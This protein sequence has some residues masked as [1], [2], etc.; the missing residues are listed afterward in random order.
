VSYEAS[1]ARLEADVL[2]RIAA[3]RQMQSGRRSL[4]VGVLLVVGALAAGLGAGIF[5]ARGAAGTL[6]SETVVLAEDSSMAPSS[7]L[8]STR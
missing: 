7:L 2:A 4:P 3:H 5:H 6:P 8:V 1:L